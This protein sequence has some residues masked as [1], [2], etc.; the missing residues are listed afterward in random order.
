MGTPLREV[1]DEVGG[2]ARPGA[3]SSPPLSGRRNP[4]HPGRRAR[5]PA[6]LRGAWQRAG[7]GLGRPG[8]SSSTTPTDLVAVAAGVSRFLAVE[9]C[10]QCTPCKQDGLAIVGSPAGRLRGPRPASATST[11]IGDRAA[12]VTDGGPLLPGPAAPA[13]G[14]ERAARLPRGARRPPAAGPGAAAEPVLDRPGRRRLA[15]RRSGDL[16]AA[17]RPSSPTGPTT[18]RTRARPPPSASSPA[19]EAAVQ[20]HGQGRGARSAD[21][22]DGEHHAPGHDEAGTVRSCPGGSSASGRRAEDHLLVGDH[23]AHPHRVHADAGRARRRRARRRTTSCWVGSAPTRPTPR[24]S[25]RAVVTAVP[26]GASTLASW[27]SS[28]ISAVSKYGAA[29]SAKRII[30]TALIAKFDGDQAVARGERRAERVDVVVVEARSCRPRRG[31]RAPPATAA[32]SRAAAAT[33]KST[34]TSAPASASASSS[35]AIV[36]PVDGCA[37]GARVDRGDELQLGSAATASHTVRPSARPRRPLRPGSSWPAPYSRRTR[38][39]RRDQAHRATVQS[40]ASS[41][42]SGPTPR[43]SG[44]AGVTE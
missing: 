10:G 28:M 43:A 1:I 35:A 9:S 18:S 24:P 11:E 22:L 5:H 27:C 26:D 8:S 4:L 31:C 25:A 2:G 36:T 40:N 29:S 38:R 6:D 32:S 15:G 14:A 30:S 21:V 13:G 33:V 41:R 37:G 17:R 20:A 12:T 39:R 44:R 23:A 42:S 7:A 34:T 19:V 16:D 3:A